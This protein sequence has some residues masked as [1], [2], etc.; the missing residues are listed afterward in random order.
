M[1][2]RGKG[3]TQKDKSRITRTE[4]KKFGHIP[5]DGLAAKVQKLV[6]TGVAVPTPASQRRRP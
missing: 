3:F 1:S 5:S 6:D 2:N 4:T